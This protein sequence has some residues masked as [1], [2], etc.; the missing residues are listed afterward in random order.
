LAWTDPLNLKGLGDLGVLRIFYGF[1]N[2]SF[3]RVRKTLKKS[4]TTLETFGE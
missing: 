3:M 2:P 1:P 4:S